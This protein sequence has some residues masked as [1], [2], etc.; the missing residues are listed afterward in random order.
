MSVGITAGNTLGNYIIQASLTPV[1]VGIATVAE[2]TFTVPGLN[3]GDQ[4]GVSAP[5][6]TAGV[7]LIGG[8]V[9]AANTL[10]LTYVNPTA[11]ALTPAAGMH[12]IE[13]SR[14]SGGVPATA[15]GG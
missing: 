4:V 11:G 2:Q 6:V 9:S 7:G 10:A 1:S 13:V 5:G 8:R 14:P 15:I 12:I 3:I